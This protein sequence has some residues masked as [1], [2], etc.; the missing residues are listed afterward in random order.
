MY[1][2]DSKSLDT[3]HM[4]ASGNYSGQYWTL[5]PVSEIPSNEYRLSNEYM[6]AGTTLSVNTTSKTITTA[7]IADD[8]HQYWLI[9]P[10]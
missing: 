9:T 1:L 6:P 2:G 4:A 10:E 8:P 7:P 3:D 5:T